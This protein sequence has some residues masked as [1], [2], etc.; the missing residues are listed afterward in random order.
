MRSLKSLN[1]K[2]KRVLVRVDFNVPL[3][4][5]KIQDNKRIKAA[6]PTIKF[7]LSKKP[8]QLIL[9]SHLGRPDGK[10][11]SFYE[12]YNLLPVEIFKKYKL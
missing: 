10:F 9:M 11:V 3:K 12:T 6:L 7:I 4:G 2:N 8:K 1:L 5:N